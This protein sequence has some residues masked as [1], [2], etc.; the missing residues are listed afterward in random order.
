MHII[1]LKMKSMIG[2]TVLAA[3]III[4]IRICKITHIGGDA[5]IPVLVSMLFW[6]YW[7]CICKA[8]HNVHLLALFRPQ[9]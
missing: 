7:I 4:N 1:T 3:Q 6:W 9:I 2:A 8:T 5:L